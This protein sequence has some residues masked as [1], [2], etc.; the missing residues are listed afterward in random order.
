[1]LC[2]RCMEDRDGL[3]NRRVEGME[4]GKDIADLRIG[5]RREREREQRRGRQRR[6]RKEKR[7]Q[8][9]SGGDRMRETARQERKGRVVEEEVET[10]D[11]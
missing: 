11:Q 1:M 3:A 9:V 8:T 4:C 6:E 7:L 5:R 10:N 2:V